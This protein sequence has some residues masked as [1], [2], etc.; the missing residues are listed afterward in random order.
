MGIARTKETDMKTVVRFTLAMLTVAATLGMS[1][2]TDESSRAV[3]TVVSLNEGNTYYSDLI[4]E[5]DSMHIFIPVDQIAVTLGNIQ[6]DGGAPLAA[7]TPFSEIVV[8]GYSVA[9]TP[10]VFSPV[11]GGM[12]LRIPSGGS[13]EGSITISSPSE[14]GALLSSLSSTAT[15]TATITFTGYNRINGGSNGDHVT[16]VGRLTVQVDNF[17]DSDGN[18]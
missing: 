5:A 15:T 7:G 4:N 6:N 18:Q 17:G 10:A 11:T 8:T 16:A 2:C 13:A 3:L 14:K 1:G 9:Y 12:T